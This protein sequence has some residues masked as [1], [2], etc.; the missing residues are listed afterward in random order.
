MEQYS[1][2]GFRILPTVVKHLLIINVLVYFATLVLHSR[3]IN[4][5]SLFAL[6]FFKSDNFHIWQYFTYMFM[7][8]SPEHLFF[9]MLAL[10]MFGTAV[11][12]YWGSKRFLLFYIVCG[13][14]AAF[15]HTCVMGFSYYG[16]ASAISVYAQD[17]NPDAFVTLCENKFARL[18]D[19]DK[20]D[21]LNSL[22]LAWR[23]SPIDERYSYALKSIDSARELLQEST[24]IC[25][26]GASGAIYG[27]LLAFGML[28]PNSIIYFRLLIPMKAKWYVVIYIGIE[29]MTGIFG[30]PDGVA[31]FA[32]LGGMLF[33]Y[34][35][36]KYW[37]KRE[38]QRW[39]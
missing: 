35:L 3:G 25:T 7:H 24:I 6:Y 38:F 29:L 14:G 21:E 18:I 28:F 19:K 37:K 4:M 10:W 2:P 36:I 33:G 5:E 30:T 31:H 17:P 8:A 34:I 16:A 26:V 11:E 9:N 27:I 23:Q 20:A 12:N 32:H 13:L 22:L 39:Y 15:L 1:P